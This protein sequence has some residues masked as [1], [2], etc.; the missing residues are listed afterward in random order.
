MSRSFLWNVG[1][2]PGVPRFEEEI[3]PLACR[4]EPCFRQS[5][6][7]TLVLKNSVG[8]SLPAQYHTWNTPECIISSGAK[9]GE[10]SETVFQCCLKQVIGAETY[11]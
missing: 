5:W 8:D 7:E 2:G 9:S 6:F 3:R 1:V 10:I 4:G 11:I